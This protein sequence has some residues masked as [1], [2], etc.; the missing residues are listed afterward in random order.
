MELKYII[1]EQHNVETA[2]VFNSIFN[3]CDIYDKHDIVSA[4]KCNIELGENAN[5]GDI[6]VICS[7]DSFTLSN[8]LD[9]EIKSRGD[10]DAKIIEHHILSSSFY[11]F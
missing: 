5:E 9:K 8:R 6:Q 1:V 10:Q 4:G 7:G 2:I 3:H 11:S